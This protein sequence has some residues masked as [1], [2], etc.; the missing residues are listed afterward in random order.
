LPF[1][2]TPFLHDFSFRLGFV[3]FSKRSIYR[4]V[5]KIKVNR[6]Y[7][8]RIQN[9]LFQD[10]NFLCIWKWYKN[11]GFHKRLSVAWLNGQIFRMVYV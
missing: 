5:N 8:K 9:N 4:F 2:A 1:R 3:I 10:R 7:G 11:L 6:K